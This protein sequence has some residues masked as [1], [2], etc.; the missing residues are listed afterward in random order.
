MNLVGLMIV[1]N[2]E[3]CLEVALRSALT[4]CDYVCVLLHRC[5]DRSGDIVKRLFDEGLHVRWM[6]T[7][8]TQ[9][10]EMTHRQQ[11]LEDARRLVS[12]ESG[13]NPTH[14]AMIDADEILAAPL[15]PKIREAIEALPD[16]AVLQVPWI[17]LRGSLMRYHANGLW[18]HRWV[19]CA[20]KDSPALEWKGDRFHHREPFGIKR[21][22]RWSSHEEGGLFHLWGVSERRLRAK[23]A[24]YKM[25]EVLRW[26]SKPVHQ[27]DSYYDLWKAKQGEVWNFENVPAWWWQGS[28]V[29]LIDEF[30]LPWQEAEILRLY[31]EHGTARFQGLDL[32]GLLNRRKPSV[33]TFSLCHATARFPGWKEAARAWFAKCDRPGNVEY[34]LAVHESD[35]AKASEQEIPDFLRSIKLVNAGRNCSVDNWNAAA[36]SALG[37]VLIN[38][39]DDFF[40]C[41]HW[42]TKLLEVI[43]DLRAQAAVDVDTGPSSRLLYFSIITR[44]YLDRLKKEYRY[45]GFFYPEYTSMYSDEE[46]TEIARHDRVVIAARQLFMEHRHPQF[47]KGQMDEVYE[48]QN[49]PEHYRTGK[50]ILM[51]RLGEFGIAVRG[52]EALKK[53]NLVVCLPGETFHWMWVSTLLQLFDEL[54]SQWNIFPVWGYNTNVYGSRAA[55]LEAC[56]T[57]PVTPDLV[58]W[59]DDDNL[60]SI[61]QFNCLVED[62]NLHPE[63]DGVAGW[64]WCQRDLQGLVWQ[65][66][67]GMIDEG[68][69]RCF[70]VE[71]LSSGPHL[72]EVA[73]T[74]FPAFL[75]RYQALIKAGPKPFRPVLTD[76]HTLGFMGEDTS[77]CQRSR[78]NGCRWFVDRRVL[79]DHL[80]IGP[81]G[82]RQQVDEQIP[83]QDLQIPGR[84]EQSMKENTDGAVHV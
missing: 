64:S 36:R 7:D 68:Q 37:D 75:M 83:V 71:E 5:T 45:D 27:I 69:K 43:P 21:A 18:G 3:W 6:S 17:I 13:Q 50:A 14:F 9:W 67:C 54:R 29:H 8:D 72:K 26:P 1:R 79:V 74:G 55:M 31:G 15:V 59:L 78:E 35:A 49:A 80:K 48:R 28:P 12:I 22:L 51:R 41:D 25:T 33:I 10:N 19:S 4:W 65:P 16:L 23:H 60:L 39:A 77:F 62:L 73:F 76:E 70:T 57:G 30:G 47:H 81:A 2:E 24:L 82:P 11:L 52:Q 38:I 53:F 42:D 44:A 40:P 58:L 46:F 56:K 34:I 61:P 84:R 63:A 32:F 66:S 20:F